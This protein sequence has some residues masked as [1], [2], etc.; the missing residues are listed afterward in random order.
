MRRIAKGVWVK[1]PSNPPPHVGQ[2][3]QSLPWMPLFRRFSYWTSNC[4]TVDYD[5]P[6]VEKISKEEGFKVELHKRR[7]R[8]SFYKELLVLKRKIR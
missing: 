7:R 2:I 6:G 4:F 8:Y 3:T 5:D 1:R